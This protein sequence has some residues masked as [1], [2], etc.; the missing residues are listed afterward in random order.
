[1]SILILWFVYL[2]QLL[3]FLFSQVRSFV[4]NMSVKSSF[5]ESVLPVCM[6]DVEAGAEHEWDTENTKFKGK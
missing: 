5:Y 2:A 6:Y 1:M 4:S 3:I